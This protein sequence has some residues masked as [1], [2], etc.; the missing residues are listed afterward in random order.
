MVTEPE[1]VEDEKDD[2]PSQKRR[3]AIPKSFRQPLRLRATLRVALAIA[4]RDL[5]A[6]FQ[7]PT[8][9]GL[10]A[11]YL[12]GCGL[13]FFVVYDFF[14]ANEATVR[15]LVRQMPLFLAVL[16][17]ILTMRSV[18]D[19]K[20]SGTMGWL[21]S[22]PVTDTQIII[23]KFLAS[24]CIVF[25]VV[26]TSALFPVLVAQ[27]GSVD[28]GQI[29]ASYIGLFMV[30]CAYAALGVLASTL[31][32]KPPLA[33]L[34]GVLLGLLCYGTSFALGFVSPELAELF[35]YV[36]FKEHFRTME[37]G[38]LDSRN[39]FFYASVIFVAL[40]LA[41]MSLGRGR[42][43]SKIVGPL[44]V[45]L[46]MTIAVGWNIGAANLVGRADLTQNSVNTLSMPSLD[47]ISKFAGLSVN[48]FV[49]PNMPDVL[50]DPV[51][52]EGNDMR[53]ARQRLLDLLEEYRA[54]AKGRM[55]VNT[56]NK[57]LEKE[58]AKAGIQPLIDRGR[59]TPY[60]FGATFKFGDVVERLP[61]ATQTKFQEFNITK[62]LV[63]LRQRAIGF[64]K[65]KEVR[66]AAK[67][68]FKATTRCLTEMRRSLTPVDQLPPEKRVEPLLSQVRLA[69][70]SQR[71]RNIKDRCHW[72][73]EVSKTVSVY[74]QQ[75]EILEQMRQ[76]SME[77]AE[78]LRIFE[79][80]MMR[81]GAKGSTPLRAA[82]SFER[83]LE[84]LSNLYISFEASPGRRT[85]GIVCSGTSFCP[86][87]PAPRFSEEDMEWLGGAKTEHRAIGEEFVTLA[88]R[89]NEEL[90]DIEQTFFRQHGFDILPVDLSRP[91]PKNLGALVIIGSVGPSSAFKSSENQTLHKFSQSEL[92][93]LDQFLLSDGA[94]AVFMNPWHVSLAETTADGSL[95]SSVE[96]NASNISTLLEHYGVKDT[97]N[98]VVE[99]RQHGQLKMEYVLDNQGGP[100]A[101]DAIGYPL[102]PTITMFDEKHPI[103]RGTE[104]VNLPFATSLKTTHPKAEA[105]LLSSRKAVEADPS[106]I[107]LDPKIL[108]DWAQD[109]STR[110]HD[111]F[112][113]AVSVE[114]RLDSFFKK[115]P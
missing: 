56:F 29:F 96:P 37:R 75:N 5:L 87:P 82:R 86:F 33:L 12:A 28:A 115:P 54:N 58:A 24:A 63:K 69:E 79:R 43:R 108:W 91:L 14:G 76:T 97:R 22:L 107:P 26:F 90:E 4:S 71:F 111:P 25:G 36:S 77:A 30:G 104:Y 95:A 53:V 31:T 106:K 15:P 114:G 52:G 42:S 93:N 84:R 66:N 112:T 88:E 73:G 51:T 68:V 83:I 2:A 19:E 18:A 101:V 99:P 13:Y 78:S 55:W 50:H 103:A 70:Y 49:S 7:N 47:V 40:V 109:E 94:L 80:H 27:I 41:R 1:T 6:T 102:I 110:S 10:I 38:V 32:T 11:L 61:S 64:K 20:R 39:L 16:I 17:P 3:F 98:F 67:T 59:D 46:S 48:L 74:A 34:I 9:Y 105:V 85:I 60:Y 62:T 72:L 100:K 44:V 57:D 113:V 21:Q 45:A 92:Y 81:R 35:S 23:G 65:I 8:A 89:I